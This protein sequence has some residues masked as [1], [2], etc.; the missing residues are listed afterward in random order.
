MFWRLC[1]CGLYADPFDGLQ[2]ELKPPFLAISHLY[3]LLRFKQ[4]VFHVELHALANTTKR[5]IWWKRLGNIFILQHSPSRVASSCLNVD[6]K[7]AAIFLFYIAPAG[8]WTEGLNQK[9]D[10]MEETRQYI[11]TST[12][13]MLYCI[14]FKSD[15]LMVEWKVRIIRTIFQVC[16][17]FL[18]VFHHP[19][20]SAIFS[21]HTVNYK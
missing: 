3:H 8:S 13:Q 15:R 11:Y 2:R 12:F 1:V 7:W 5:P 16:A 20:V 10:L 9:T 19:L 6:R 4:N 21:I 14:S 17:E 18:N